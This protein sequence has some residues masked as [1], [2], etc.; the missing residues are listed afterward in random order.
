MGLL[1]NIMQDDAVYMV[2]TDV[3]GESIT[4]TPIGGV[5]AT[6]NAVVDRRPPEPVDGQGYGV[7]P[8]VVISLIRDANGTNGPASV[9]AGD[10]VSLPERVGESSRTMSVITVVENDTRMW[11][12]QC[13]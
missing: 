3:F 10:K 5:A 11:V 12:L 2:D 1:D 6:Y 4:Y 7:A 13:R 9:A 8:N